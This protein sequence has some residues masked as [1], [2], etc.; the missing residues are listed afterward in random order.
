M[1]NTKKSPLRVEKRF[2]FDNYNLTSNFMKEIDDLCKLRNIYPN[3]SFGGKFVSITI[4]LEKEDITEEEK[5]FLFE[6]D[7]QYKLI[8]S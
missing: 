3:I 1:W 7:A 6:I 2:E 8:K 4:F 5:K